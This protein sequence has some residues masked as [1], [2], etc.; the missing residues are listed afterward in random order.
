MSVK[1]AGPFSASAAGFAVLCGA[2]ALL[3]ATLSAPD[4]ADRHPRVFAIASGESLRDVG[5][6][7]RRAGLIRNSLAFEILARISLRGRRIH[8]GLYR[9]APT[10]NAPAVLN[11]LTARSTLARL[12][13]PE[14]YSIAQIAA[15]ADRQ[16]I[17]SAAAVEDAAR[18]PV[19]YQQRFGWLKALP[20]GASLEGFLFP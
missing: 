15:L 10:M 16:G 5:A 12:T 6:A 2:L 17:A 3:A 7:L 8:A 19:P 14:G 1:R 13:V 18:S 20:T 9:L 11:V 4:L